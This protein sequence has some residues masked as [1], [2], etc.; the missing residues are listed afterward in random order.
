MTAARWT[1]T[2][3][4]ISETRRCTCSESVRSAHRNSTPRGSFSAAFRLAGV[5]RSVATTRR[6]SSASLRTVAEPTR[7]KAPVMRTVPFSSVLMD[8]YSSNIAAGE[9]VVVGLIDVIELVLGG[10]GFVEQ[11]LAAP[12]Q[13]Y[14]ARDVGARVGFA[15]K[16]SQEPFLEQREQRQRQRRRHVGHRCQGGDHHGTALPHRIERVVDH[17]PFE[18]AWRQDRRVGHDSTRNL[19]NQ[20]GCFLHR[21]G[22]VSSSELKRFVALARLNIEYDDLLC[23]RQPRALNGTAADAPAAHHEHHIAGTDI[24]GIDGRTP[25]G[26]YAAAEKTCAR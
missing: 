10:D 17:R 13:A 23:S 19:A 26:G 3:G 5:S 9:H 25:A 21:G 16:A 1:I 22:K 7:P 18:H 2:S 14:Q 15:V 20:L 8:Y 4:A 24:R 6:P 12:V 11:Q